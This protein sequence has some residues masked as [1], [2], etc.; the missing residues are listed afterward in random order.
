VN[1]GVDNSGI[2]PL[3]GNAP[4]RDEPTQMT[5]QAT[6]PHQGS[7]E[8]LPPPIGEAAALVARL[9]AGSDSHDAAT[10][11][12]PSSTAAPD[13]A[14]T[15]PHPTQTAH[16]EL[17]ATLLPD[18]PD[19]KAAALTPSPNVRTPLPRSK[20]AIS[21]MILALVA[22]TFGSGLAVGYGILG[23]RSKAAAKST[24][25]ETAPAPSS[26]GAPLLTADDPATSPNTATTSS[27]KSTPDSNT[28][29]SSQ[30]HAS[31]SDGTTVTFRQPPRDMRTEQPRST[32]EPSHAS[33]D[34]SVFASNPPSTDPASA[35]PTS[36]AQPPG[37][38]TLPGDSPHSPDLLASTNAPDAPVTT[39]L[40]AADSEARQPIIASLGH[41]EPSE[42]VHS[43]QPVYPDEAKRLHVEGDVQLRVVVG[44]DG[45]VQSVSLISGPPLL[46]SAA[47]D[48]ARQFRY[49]PALL[50][51]QPIETVQTIAMSFNLEN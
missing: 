17:F 16:S 33:L 22:L 46:T 13:P 36:S 49:T 37:S 29:P 31:L 10:N 43:V 8:V 3:F 50:D 1:H 38:T 12:A 11:E 42:L 32:A 51:G 47:I 30:M 21:L 27:T 18:H 7:T 39:E 14:P 41:I 23:R 6:S 9:L 24:A 34:S 45:A 20:T 35:P 48:A 25:Q 2:F 26:S 15:D 4:A 28:P 40:P 44:T 5:N 19:R